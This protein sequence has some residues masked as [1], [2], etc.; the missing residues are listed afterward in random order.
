MVGWQGLV[1]ESV[2]DGDSGGVGSGA[3]RGAGWRAGQGRGQQQPGQDETGGRGPRVGG[4]LLGLP[5]PLLGPLGGSAG[6]VLVAL[7]VELLVELLLRERGQAGLGPG[8]ILPLPEGLQA[9]PQAQ[10]L[11]VAESGPVSGS[12]GGPRFPCWP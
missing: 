9:L 3:G 6:V 11:P 5:G 10:P 2:A 4:G 12:A 1:S 7:A 8:L